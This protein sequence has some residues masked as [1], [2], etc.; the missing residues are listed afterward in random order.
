MKVLSPCNGNAWKAAVLFLLIGT[1]LAIVQGCSSACMKGTPL[2][3]G[4]YSKPQAPPEERVNIWPAFYYHEPA[5]SILWPIGESTEDHL[6]V[7]PLFSVYKL[8][9]ERHK[10][11][12]LWPLMEFDF[13]THDHRIFP[14]FWSV[15][16][17][18]FTLFPFVWYA[19]DDYFTLFPLLWYEPG[20]SFTLFPLL[21]YSPDDYFALFPLFMRFD[22]PAGAS[23]HALWP[24]FK[25]KRDGEDL[26]WRVWPLVGYK[27]DG[28]ERYRYLLWPLVHY[29]SDDTLEESV[30]VAFPLYFSGRAPDEN[31]DV[32][33]PLFGRFSSDDDSSFFS[34]IYNSR[35]DGDDF[36]RLLLPL[37][38]QSRSGAEQSFVTPIIGRNWSPEHNTWSFVPLVSWFSAK[39]SQRDLWLLG[40]WAHFR[41]GAVPSSHVFPLY[42]YDGLEDVLLTP[43]FGMKKSDGDG[44]FNLL[45][46]LFT[47]CWGEANQ[48]QW[49][50]IW[51]F[52][53]AYDQE[54]A[55]G[56]WFW[57][58]FSYK[59]YHDEER[60]NGY[61]LWPLIHYGFSPDRRHLAFLPFFYSQ[62]S[63]TSRLVEETGETRTQR[64][65]SLYL[66]P[67]FWSRR[68]NVES[69]AKDESEPP[70]ATERKF[71]A[72][73]PLW[74]YELD[75]ADKRL[76]KDFSVLGW[77]YDFR[78]R[79]TEE[80]GE[81]PAEDYRRSHILWRVL[82]YER[83]EGHKSLDIIP[84]I[85]YDS[86]EKTGF[87][88]FS[89][90]WR[91]FRYQRDRDGEVTADLLFLP[92]WR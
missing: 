5:M 41:W 74:R 78:R 23:T 51:P 32:L 53:S 16:E 75:R 22:E 18:Y 76:E 63:E 84:F 8:D 66:F 67:T 4:E 49:Y 10:Y 46:P 48:W 24:I 15:E 57:P 54:D 50:G 55:H 14:F 31:W 89:F 45:G 38:F 58:L 25:F 52:M 29:W 40:P 2:Y 11:N 12:V 47:Y 87:R 71:A 1:I 83:R 17:A 91:L 13:D 72:L 34:L 69:Q 90:A 88:K 36:W 20:Y 33:V 6:A 73:W 19:L 82:H 92:I 21:W 85:T 44:F 60:R 28:D 64:E 56:G 37:Y 27:T 68:E 7:R 65:R 59:R 86:E 61:A 43:L 79:A 81:Q 42:Y 70:I 77:L 9:Q 80:E 39:G 3:T 35:R 30:R 26:D 62:R